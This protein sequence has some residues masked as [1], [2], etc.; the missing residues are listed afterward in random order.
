MKHRCKQ[1]GWSEEVDLPSAPTDD[2][3][4]DALALQQWAKDKLMALKDDEHR[5][6]RIRA[7]AVLELVEKVGPGEAARLMGV[8]RTLVYKLMNHLKKI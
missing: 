7:A 6:S 3:P 1:C 8:Q 5:L 4:T 2:A